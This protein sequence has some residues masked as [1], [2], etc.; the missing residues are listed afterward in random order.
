MK[1]YV[2]RH[3]SGCVGNCLL[4]WRKGGNGYTCNLDEAQVFDDQEPRLAQILE[5]KDKF[6]AWERGYVDA[7]AHRHVN[8]EYINHDLCGLQEKGG[9]A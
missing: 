9:K 5:S 7:V 6:T 2:Q 3:A 4:W 1:Y 8:N